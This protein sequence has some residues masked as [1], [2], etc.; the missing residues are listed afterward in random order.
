MCLNAEA[1]ARSASERR[2]SFGEAHP[3]PSSNHATQLGPI[4]DLIRLAS[5]VNLDSIR[6]FFTTMASGSTVSGFSRLCV[7]VSL[8][9]RSDSSA[10][11]LRVRRGDS[12]R[13]FSRCPPP[14]TNGHAKVPSFR[15]A[16]ACCRGHVT[17][18]RDRREPIPANGKRRW[19]DEESG[20]R[21]T[22]HLH[23]QL[24][25][26]YVFGRRSEID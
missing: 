19:S 7:R 13:R 21:C 3:V 18:W 22:S 16:V 5:C 1:I 25:E 23:A 4:R 9:S 17:C 14:Y 15:H 11:Y 24:E 12:P 2:H 6:S 20:T 26:L 8:E 10:V